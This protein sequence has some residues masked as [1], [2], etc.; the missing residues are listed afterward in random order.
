M[1]TARAGAARS[2][3]IAP[4]AWDFRAEGVNDNLA[5]YVVRIDGATDVT[6]DG[7]EFRGVDHRANGAVAVHN[8]QRITLRELA[9]SD[10]RYTGLRVSSSS[11]ID[12]QVIRIENAGYEWAPGT[13]SQFPDGGSVG[14]LG[15]SNVTDALFAHLQIRTSALRG[16]GI[17]G[18]GWTRVRL[19]HSEFDLHP[20]QSWMGPG[21]GNFDIEIHGNEA[22]YQRVP[23]SVHV[24]HNLF[25]QKSGAYGIEV[26]TDRMVVDHNR[27]RGTWTALQNYGGATTRIGDLT[28]ANNVAETSMRLV[29]LKGRVENLR[30]FGNTVL[31][32]PGG[33][34]S[35]LVTLGSNNG[36][37]NWLI[38]NNIVTG[39]T[40]NAAGNR[41]L[42]V[43]YNGGG[44]PRDVQVRNNLLQDIAPAIVADGAV[45][46]AA[47]NIVFSGTVQAA[48]QL[49]ASGAEQ[50]VP[51]AAS[52]AV[53]RGAAAAGIRSGV[54]GAGRDIG[55]F[56]RGETPWTAGRGSESR[57]QYLWAPTTSVRQDAFVT[58]LDV[59]LAAAAGA[60]LR[61]TLDGSEPGPDAPLYTAP[62]RVTQA[63]K[64][65]ARSFANGFGSATALSLDLAQGIRG[66]PNLSTTATASA[67]SNFPDTAYSPAQAIDGVTYSW[68]GWAA[69]SNDARPWLQLDLGRAA[70]IRH[71]ELFTRAQI[72]ADDT[73]PR[74][75]FEI[76]A[77]NDPDFGSYVV[78]AAQGATALPFEGVFE[79]APTDTG[80][81]RYVRAV[82]TAAEWFFVAELVVRGEAP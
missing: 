46:P 28:V 16:Y 70:R 13:S 65:R 27:F 81:Y 75:S 63:V 44:A 42:V 23:Y 55:A 53:D 12:A 21:P 54:V 8:A 39:S 80:S 57:V 19:L 78:L 20:F 14:N 32:G 47:S 2:T 82:K 35:Y 59:D 51:A 67:S 79:A 3:V 73:A 24:H 50:F 29:G 77:S 26:G 6:V 10:F 1:S 66:Y 25:D 5:G 11:A 61:Y 36:S 45:D 48:P 22:R 9:I 49:V 15:I 71:I 7:I 30:V 38:A 56:E 41:Q 31:L 17:K 76:R 40:A 4:A 37:R 43:V 69:G 64:L 72:G 34:Q 68:Q 33:G 52:P 58:A 60:Q 62:I 74:R 18:G